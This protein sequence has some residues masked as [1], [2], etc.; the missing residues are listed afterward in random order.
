[1]NRRV[2]IIGGGLAGLAAAVRLAENDHT[3]I[4][5]ETR[6]KLG[7][8]ATS[9]MDPRSG[10]VLDN[11]QHVLMGCCTNL[12]DLY[13]R[14]GV[15]DLIEWH[16]TLYWTAGRGEVYT[17]KPLPLPGP[18]HLARGPR[19]LRFLKSEDRK[20]IRRAMW[21][22]IRMGR[23]GRLQW[24]GR[25]FLDFLQNTDQTPGAV[26][27]FWS[28]IIISTCNL[29]PNR[30]DAIHG[31]QVFQDGFLPNRWSGTMGLSTVPLVDLYDPIAQYITDLGGE[32]K[33]GCSARSIAYDGS[34]I[35]GVVTSDDKVEASAVI[36]AVSPDR[37]HKL[38]SEALRDADARLQNLQSF[39][40]SPIIGVHLLFD[41]PVMDIPH[42]T[43]VDHDTQWLFNKG[44]DD[45]GRQHIHAVISAADRWIDLTEDTIVANVLHDMHDALPGSRGLEPT[46][47]R[48]VKEKRAT[49]AATPEA[50]SIRPP[51]APGYVGTGGGGVKNLLLAGDWC[52]TGW[53]ATMEG[54]VRSG[55]AAAQ[56][57]LG[58]DDL[59]AD[60]VP[61]S[62]P[63]RMLG[64]K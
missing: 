39:D 11:C 14:A 35:T 20:A 34:R 13:Q 25:V 52:D 3:P 55:Y 15:L 31:L 56:A 27:F 42:L 29:E 57:I 6:R 60:E 33:M 38:T 5:V 62:W 41:Q 12:I 23:R 44:V 17:V 1:M 40:Y 47:A 43:L 8:R 19:Q 46:Q 53:P 54:A 7:G 64:L 26:D 18:L 59:L 45:A 30:V 48:S 63:A 2:T 32:L 9:F 28:P 36:S 21:R 4:L 58:G 22:I 24:R 49:F 10:D 16:E 50:E 61:A 37:L 51:T